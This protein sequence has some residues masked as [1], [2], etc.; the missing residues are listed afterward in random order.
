[1]MVTS[2]RELTD[3]LFRVIDEAEAAESAFRI[4]ND[5][6][7]LVRGFALRQVERA[8]RKRIANRRKMHE[9]YGPDIFNPNR[10]CPCTN[11]PQLAAEIRRLQ[12]QPKHSVGGDG[13]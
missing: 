13:D 4:S 7:N 2:D 9:K 12:D 5:P 1:M 11:S 3:K 10:P 6:Q 8:V